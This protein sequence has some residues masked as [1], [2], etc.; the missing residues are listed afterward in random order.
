MSVQ[1]AKPCYCKVNNCATT[2]VLHDCKDQWSTGACPNSANAQGGWVPQLRARVQFSDCHMAHW[3]PSRHAPACS[4]SHQCLICVPLWPVSGC[5]VL[6]AV[7]RIRPT[8][9]PQAGTAPPRL[10]PR[11]LQPCA[12]A[13]CCMHDHAGAH[14]PPQALWASVS[15]P[16]ALQLPP[17]IPCALA[18]RPSSRGMPS[19]C[20]RGSR[21]QHSGG[22]AELAP[23]APP[24]D[25]FVYVATKA[26]P[27]PPPAASPAVQLV[28][29]AC[30]A[31]LA[32]QS[33]SGTA[34]HLSLAS[35][36]AWSSVQ[37]A[38]ARPS[39]RHSAHGCSP[40]TSRARCV[41]NHHNHKQLRSEDVRQCCWAKNK[42]GAKVAQACWP[43]HAWQAW[44]SVLV[45]D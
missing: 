36:T 41:Y 12:C 1:P 2:L 38:A 44:Q 18:Y 8:S 32:G 4:H 7:G 27:Q 10:R 9:R 40:V 21:L 37:K 28:V 23:A 11:Q 30:S 24:F 13:A 3:Q 29:L 39:Q 34:L 15:A 45:S 14:G 31:A 25:L 43:P 19:V 20:W 5:A 6:F 26:V 35:H 42:C 16:R 33:F 22:S 17:P